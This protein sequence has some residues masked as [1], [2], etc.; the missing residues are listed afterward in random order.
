MRK[1]VK[2]LGIA[3]GAAV[4]LVV[5]LS[6]TVLADSPDDET[7]TPIGEGH[8]WRGEMGMGNESMDVVSDLLELTT[9]EIHALRADGY[10]LA[11]IA[12]DYHVSVDELVA[13]I[14]AEKTELINARVAEGTIT[15]ERADLMIKNM[16]Q[17]TLEAVNR[18]TTGPAEWRGTNG[19]KANGMFGRAGTRGYRG[20]AGTGACTGT[21]TNMMTRFNNSY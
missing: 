17:R 12:A 5:S 3:L 21:G 2:I 1:G 19:M 9:D 10:S 11:E 15:Q 7:C 8:G 18:T 13:A 16:E 14:M 6:A 4:L 20:G